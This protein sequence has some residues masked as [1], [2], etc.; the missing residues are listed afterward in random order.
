NLSHV[1]WLILSLL[2]RVML[3]RNNATIVSKQRGNKKTDRRRKPPYALIDGSSPE[4]CPKTQSPSVMHQFRAPF[5]QECQESW[6][7]SPVNWATLRMV[8]FI[9]PCC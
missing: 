3:L 5:I 9:V 8:L 7:F 2:L 1:K 4:L 6:D